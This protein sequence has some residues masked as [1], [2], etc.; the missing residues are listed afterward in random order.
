MRQGIVHVVGAGVAGLSAATALAEDGRSVRLYEAAPQAGGRCRSYVD[1]ALATTIDNG[2]HIILSGNHAALAYLDRLGTRDCLQGPD[3]A[4]FDFVDLRDGKRWRIQPSHGRIPWW[5]L[6]KRKRVPGTR[7]LDYLK[8]ISLRFAQ[9][10]T[11]IG[12][13]IPCQ[14]ALY[15]RLWHPLLLAALNTEPPIAS[16]ALAGAVIRQSLERGG[17]AC[18]PLTARAGLSAAFIDPAIAFLERHGATIHLG[19]RLRSVSLAG[20]RA[21]QLF[22]G[23]D[24]VEIAAE[25]QVILAVPAP[26]ASQLL[27]G[28]DTPVEHR[29][30]VNGH[31]KITPGAG[32]PPILGVVGGEAEWIFSYPDRISTTTSSAD[33]LVDLPREVLAERLWSDVKKALGLSAP[34]PPWQIVKERRATFAALPREDMRRPPAKT[35]W[36]NIALAGDYTATNLPATI[37]GAIRS[38]ATA[39]DI[40]Q[41][42]ANRSKDASLSSRK[43]VK[44]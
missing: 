31:F 29:A 25:D 28:V 15:E 11:R 42:M 24:V 14:G 20:E 9:P 37:E 26:V 2:N 6:S 7:A 3:R 5:I 16:A 30:I 38:G 18:R 1:Q 35:R 43:D 4:Y 12:D 33:R 39:A 32:T 13:V 34:M 23:D 36:S 8:L 10:G 41:R 44:I 17:K 27:P 22:F 40:V 21:N 19:S